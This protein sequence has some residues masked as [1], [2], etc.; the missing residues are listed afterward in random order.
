MILYFLRHA[1]AGQ[2]KL[3]PAK[4]EKRTLDNLGIE[5]SHDVGHA[6]A[7]LNL[8]VDVILSSPLPRALQTAEIV[9]VE[10]RHMDKIVTDDALRPEASYADFQDLLDRYRKT[11]SLMLAGHNPSLTEFI[12]KFLAGGGSFKGIELKKGAVAKLEKEGKGAP[13]LKWLLPPKVARA[14]Q[15]GSA[16]K[17]RP[18]TVLK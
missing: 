18:K 4:D 3:D 17:S 12:N 16:S 1:N 15:K 9:A 11:E 13:T 8:K 14:L 7:A 5:Q 10:I 2:P 6:L